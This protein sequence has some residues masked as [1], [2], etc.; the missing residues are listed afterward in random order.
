MWSRSKGPSIVKIFKL[1]VWACGGG[2]LVF[3]LRV[4]GAMRSFRVAVLGQWAG[5]QM[6]HTQMKEIRRLTGSKFRFPSRNR[7]NH[8]I[9]YISSSSH[10]RLQKVWPGKR[11]S[12]FILTGEYLSIHYV[13]SCSEGTTIQVQLSADYSRTE[14]FNIMPLCV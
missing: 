9:R 2:W 6:C 1:N 13:L 5:L 10:E 12:Y 11:T 3:I 7:N 8:C 14:M 4:R